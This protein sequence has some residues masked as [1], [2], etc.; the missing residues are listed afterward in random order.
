[1]KAIYIKPGKRP[2]VVDID[3]R[4]VV[5]QKMVEGEIDVI[6]PFGDDPV[7]ITC[8]ENGQG[9]KPNRT[10]RYG[11]SSDVILGNFLIVGLGKYR[12]LPENLVK[13]YTEMFRVPEKFKK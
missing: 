6:Y 13:K 10:I 7:A 8:N 1:M 4:L 3:D 11:V 12:S 5:L 2:E 9:L